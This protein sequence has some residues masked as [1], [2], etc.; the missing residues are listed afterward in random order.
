MRETLYDVLIRQRWLMMIG[1]PLAFGALT[2]GLG[3]KL[4]YCAMLGM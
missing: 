2:F 4:A 1:V 3:P